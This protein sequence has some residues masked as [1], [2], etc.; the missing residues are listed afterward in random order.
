[1]ENEN[2]ASGVFK[3]FAIGILAV[4]YGL[5]IRGCNQNISHNCEEEKHAKIKAIYCEHEK[6]FKRLEQG[7]QKDLIYLNKMYQKDY[8]YKE[9]LRNL[10][11][12]R[13]SRDYQKYLQD[14]NEL[15]QKA[16]GEK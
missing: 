10:E 5:A 9:K 7:Y 2:N 14:F 13:I 16:E 15:E 12:S 6:E 3:G 4:F 1:M 11:L 8:A